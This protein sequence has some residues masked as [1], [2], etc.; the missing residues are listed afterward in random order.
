MVFGRPLRSSYSHSNSVCR[1]SVTFVSCAQTAERIEFVF[2]MPVTLDHSDHVLDGHPNP[3]RNG[4]VMGGGSF[5]HNGKDRQL[6]VQ[7]RISGER[8]QLRCWTQ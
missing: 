5:R 3:P 4:G 7:P 6:K 2:G 8:L 1:L